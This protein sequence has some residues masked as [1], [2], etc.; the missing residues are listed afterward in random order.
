MKMTGNM[1]GTEVPERNFG[2]NWG[3][4]HLGGH[5]LVISSGQAG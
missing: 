5:D 2:K 4:R 1:H 3:M